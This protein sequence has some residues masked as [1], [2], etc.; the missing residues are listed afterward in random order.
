MTTDG[1]SRR[2]A[3]LFRGLGQRPGRPLNVVAFRHACP[4][5]AGR[6]LQWPQGRFC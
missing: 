4:S 6:A 1:K 3:P 5:C 2:Y